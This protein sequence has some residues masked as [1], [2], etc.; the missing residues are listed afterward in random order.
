MQGQQSK[1][2]RLEGAGIVKKGHKF[3]PDDEKVIENLT[4]EEVDSLISIKEKLGDEFLYK[5]GGRS[6]G[7]LF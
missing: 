6:A 7:I 2:E 3:S 1:K 4:D 5:H